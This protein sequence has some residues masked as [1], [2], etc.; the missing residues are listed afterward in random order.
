MSVN[1]Q[2]AKIKFM[3][4]LFDKQEK[5]NSTISQSFKLQYTGFM[6]W[7]QKIYRKNTELTKG[8]VV[9]CSQK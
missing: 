4:P 6:D 5:T 3:T 8:N 7:L 1:I 2:H 9:M